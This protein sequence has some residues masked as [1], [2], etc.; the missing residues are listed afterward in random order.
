MFLR[1]INLLVIFLIGVL[2][3]GCASQK[4]DV[5]ELTADEIKPITVSEFTLG[6]NDIIDV[7]VWRNTELSRKIQVDPYGKILLIFFT[8]Q[9]CGE[10]NPYEIKGAMFAHVVA[11]HGKRS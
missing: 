1:K 5:K 4:A 2:L 9:S 11:L 6:P 8:Q 7:Q 3:S 10:F